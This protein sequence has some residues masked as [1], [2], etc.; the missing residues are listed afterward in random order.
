MLNAKPILI[1]LA[2]IGLTGCA[3]PKKPEMP[4]S[5]YTTFAGR[6]LMVNYCSWKGWMDADT[7]ARG[8]TYIESDVATWTHDSVRLNQI[9]KSLE[10]E[11]SKARQG[12]CNLLTASIQ[13]RKQQIENNNATAA[14]QQQEAQNMINATRPTHTYCNRIGTQVL[15]NSF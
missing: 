10:P 9:I 8:R 15:C 4:E 11:T 14:M 1:S 13:Q 5:H 7:A 12:D 3:T 2:F 6:W